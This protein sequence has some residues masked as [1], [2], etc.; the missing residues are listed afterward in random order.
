MGDKETR[1]LL[2]SAHEFAMQRTDKG[3]D[4]AAEMLL[5]L[6]D[7]GC[8]HPEV[9]IKTATYLLQGSHG[10]EPE[11][12][13][14]VALML[15]KIAVKPPDDINLIEEALHNY[16]LIQSD[17]PEKL[18]NIIRLCLTILNTNPDHV[19]SMTVLARNRKHF[20]VALSLEDAIRMLEWA[21]ELEPD[22]ILAALTLANLYI[23]AGKYASANSI[24][25]KINK[26]ARED[27]QAALK[28]QNQSLSQHPRSGKISSL[29]TGLIKIRD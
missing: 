11:I 17:H 16:E 13:Y 24:Y 28:K 19:E 25:R 12:H 18:N 22:N 7:N 4:K 1:K 15:D 20:E 27:S 9:L 21:H 5:H 6:V 23:E 2:A 29:N 3:L 26:I 14:K 8:E 10:R